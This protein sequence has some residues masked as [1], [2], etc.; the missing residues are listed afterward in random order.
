M[1][2]PSGAADSAISVRDV[3]K[4]FGGFTALRDVSLDFDH[5]S[6]HALV[7]ANGAGK[8]TLLGVLA[9]RH[10]PSRGAVYLNGRHLPA[11]RP[12]DIATAGVAAIYQELTIAANVSAIENVF[13][14]RL[15]GSNGLV[16]RRLMRKR[17]D[18]LCSMVGVAIPAE[19]LAGRLPVA[20][21][22]MLE[23]MRAL[24]RDA[25]VVLLDEP[26]SALGETHRHRLFSLMR[27]LRDRGKTLI[28]VSHDL[29]DVLAIADAISVF[30]DGRLVRT[31][32]TQSWSRSDLLEAMLGQAGLGH[33]VRDARDEDR[34]GESRQAALEVSELITR[35]GREPMSFSVAAGEIL[36]LA[37]LDGS[38]RS[39]TLQALAGARPAVSGRIRIGKRSIRAP[40]SI[41]GAQRAGIGFVPED[42][43]QDG[44]I[45]TLSAAANI[46]LLSVNSGAMRPMNEKWCQREARRPAERVGLPSQ[47]LARP[48]GALSGG[49]QQKLLLARWLRSDLKVLLVDQPTRGVDVGAKAEILSTLRKLAA[50]GTAVVTTSSELEELEELCHRVLV[51]RRGAVVAEL[52]HER[53]DL[54]VARM[55]HESF[56]GLAT[57][58]ERK[59]N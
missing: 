51:L 58:R 37:G 44:V 59:S 34:H 46:V 17:Y 42:R 20:R 2:E 35:T 45:T 3:S 12:R 19:A 56:G 21:Q 5:G 47:Y 16:S 55:L 53:G 36:G 18:E 13:L 25:Q 10:R 11:G 54:S 41:R 28:F 24:E 14:G 40:R 48:A 29:D 27:D 43:K 9:G 38:G 6:I 49:N 32:P 8:S 31:E 57:T 15:P 52:S 7:G 39:S 33:E 26:T 50:D 30:R 4:R 23:I 1:T 22:Q